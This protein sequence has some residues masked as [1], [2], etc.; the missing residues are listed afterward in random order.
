[1]SKKILE[2]C[3]NSFSLDAMSFAQPL[4]LR[5]KIHG[6]TDGDIYNNKVGVP[7]LHKMFVTSARNRN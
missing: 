4:G 5:R 3:Q 2:S 7:C 6:K 1:M